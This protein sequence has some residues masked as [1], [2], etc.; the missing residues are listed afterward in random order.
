MAAAHH[1]TCKP[2]TGRRHFHLPG[3][4]PRVVTGRPPAPPFPG[5]LS[6]A[7]GV[8]VALVSP[9]NPHGR[10]RYYAR[11][12]HRQ[13]ECRLRAK[14]AVP[15][16][17]RRPSAPLPAAGSGKRAGRSQPASPDGRRHWV[18]TPAN[19]VLY[20]ASAAVFFIRT[21]ST[22]STL[23]GGSRRPESFPAILSQMK[24]WTV[25]AL[26]PCY[27]AFI[28]SIA[29]MSQF[30]PENQH[31][32]LLLTRPWLSGHIPECVFRKTRVEYSS[33]KTSFP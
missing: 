23:R 7:G 29:T 28:E 12:L 18:G 13:I 33:V 3:L 5:S 9:A 16:P 2:C 11:S 27:M 31:A 32:R 10:L 21:A 6:P 14:E 8:P 25:S 4:R 22:I 19:A 20:P 24:H 15:R 26:S 17:G 1:G 30:M